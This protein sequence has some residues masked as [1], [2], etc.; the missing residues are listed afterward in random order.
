MPPCAV[1]C[2]SV[3]SVSNKIVTIFKRSVKRKYANLR[4][5]GRFRVQGARAFRPPEGQR[6]KNVESIG[7]FTSAEVQLPLPLFDQNGCRPAYS[8]TKF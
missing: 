1:H 6:R 5:T 4:M 3:I 2:E 8:V 7:H